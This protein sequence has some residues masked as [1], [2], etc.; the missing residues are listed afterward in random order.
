M[1]NN[2][3]QWLDCW[4]VGTGTELTCRPASSCP[5]TPND[6]SANPARRWRS[7]IHKTDKYCKYFCRSRRF[8]LFYPKRGPERE[9]SVS[10][11][12]SSTVNIIVPEL[13]WQY[14]VPIGFILSR[15]IILRPWNLATERAMAASKD[16]PSEQ[17]RVF[18]NARE[19]TLT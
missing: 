13:A 10:I 14:T 1:T 4:P 19:L 6:D 12:K 8:N 16:V 7:S 11:R 9:F 15:C 18:R 2:L 17:Y 5:G 3:D